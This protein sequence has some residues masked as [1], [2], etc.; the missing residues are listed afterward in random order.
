M[1]AL[2]NLIDSAR[3]YEYNENTIK[4]GQK[5]PKFK[6]LNI[7]GNIVTFSELLKD[8]AIILL[9]YCGNWYPYCNLE[10]KALQSLI[11]SLMNYEQS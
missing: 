8:G 5:A 6:L 2:D 7:D 9:F 10:L 11:A 4:V 1:K 3:K